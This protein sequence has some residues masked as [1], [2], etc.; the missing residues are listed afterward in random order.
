MKDRKFAFLIHPRN[1]Q[2][3]FKVSEVFQQMTLDEIEETIKCIPPVAGGEIMDPKGKHIGWTIVIPLTARQMLE[4]ENLHLAKMRIIQAIEKAR[5]LGCQL[6]GLGMFTSSLTG[7]G[8]KLIG[9][10]AG[11]G[12]TNGNSLTAA[13]TV[14]GV[15]KL[16]TLL[17]KELDNIAIV[18]VGSVG[19]AVAQILAER[20]LPLL[21]IGRSGKKLRKQLDFLLRFSRA[22]I[23]ISTNIKDILTRDI[24]IATTSANGTIIRPEYLAPGAIVYDVTQPKNTSSLVIEARPD[25]LVVDGALV[26]TPNFDWGMDIGLKPGIAYACLAETLLLYLE[27]RYE[28]Y[29]IGEVTALQASEMHDLMEKHGFE[30][31]PFQSFGRLLDNNMLDKYLSV[32]VGEKKLID[33]RG[34]SRYCSRYNF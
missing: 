26:S 33:E 10:I 16:V 30:L 28:N 13:V 1:P 14:L 5:E 6:I 19:F 27:G 20:K 25:V 21:L 23:Q 8:G 7:G 3:M 9:K 22:E 2:D 18:G 34:D 29:S 4:R 32:I 17:D 15:E 24:I 31:A 12:V 11:M